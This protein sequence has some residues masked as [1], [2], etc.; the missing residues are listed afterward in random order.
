MHFSS[1]H[2]VVFYQA[3]WYLST[4]NCLMLRLRLYA[5]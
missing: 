3:A 5:T 2:F 1:G 4:I